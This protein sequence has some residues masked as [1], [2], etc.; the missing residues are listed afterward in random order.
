M[1]FVARV[2]CCNLI[3]H[4]VAFSR[5]CGVFFS[6]VCTTD[7]EEEEKRNDHKSE[8]MQHTSNNNP[9]MKK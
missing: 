5:Q 9:K 3:R 8:A 2:K 6:V 4:A 1:V 7:E